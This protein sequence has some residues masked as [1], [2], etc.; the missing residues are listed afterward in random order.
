[1]TTFAEFGLLTP[2]I[3]SLEKMLITV[4]TPVQRE[5]IP[6]ALKRNDILASAQTGTGKTIAYLIPL[7]MNLS[8]SEQGSALILA[9]T[10]ELAMQV[11]RTL[12]QILGKTFGFKTAILIGGA[13]MSN[14]MADL[15]RHPRFV[16]GTPGRI[17]DHLERKTL[18]LKDTRFLIIDEADR[19]LD[20]GFGPQ[21]DQIVS[22]LPADRQTLMFSA[23]LPPNIER[24]SQKYLK[25][26]QRISIDSKLQAD[27]KIKQEVIRTNSAD[28]HAELL[29]QLGER[30]GSIIV[31]VRT[32]RRADNLTKQLKTHGHNVEAMH[33]DLPQRRR[34][35]VVHAFRTSKSRIM[36]ATDVAAR[37]LDIPHVMH[38]INYDL[39]DCPEDYV[40]RI[41]RTG[42]AD[43]EGFAL[44]LVSP[45]ENVKWKAI[46]RILN[47]GQFG[48]EQSQQPSHRRPS[49][50]KTWQKK[51]PFKSFRNGPAHKHK[52]KKGS[53]PKRQ[54]NSFF[55]HQ[56]GRR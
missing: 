24:L 12:N 48:H 18:T 14:Q 13:S 32:R 45:E 7:I 23:T 1:M 41:G 31:F 55:S 19:M 17:N 44:S 40:H 22:F 51:R 37:G 53:F 47:P 46:A 15:R 16:V 50:N 36:V 43:A 21:L 11:H 33:G 35:K 10:R 30:K 28:K 26:P 34:E 4:P 42:R 49:S 9:P 20:M 39:P 52:S 29:K 8:N 6:L 3:E 27:P 2:L 38:V 5:T 56:E 25:N 54:K